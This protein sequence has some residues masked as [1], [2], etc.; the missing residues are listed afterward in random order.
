MDAIVRSRRTHLG[1]IA[2]SGVFYGVRGAYRHAGLPGAAA[3]LGG[4]YLLWRW[5]GDPRRGQLR[6]GL[7]AFA[8]FNLELMAVQ[9]ERNGC[10]KCFGPRR[11]G[12]D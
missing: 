2:W 12:V 6:E 5:L 4:S 7:E 1:V 3:V 11:A 9:H 8:S 10:V